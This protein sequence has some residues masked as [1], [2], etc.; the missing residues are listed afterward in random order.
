[1]EVI[2]Y[3]LIILS[4]LAVIASPGPA[5]LAIV[6]ASMSNGRSYGL[7]LALGVLTVS[8]FWSSIAAFGLAALL[9]SHA[10]LFDVIR[11]C[12]AIYLI[13]SAYK[14]ARSAFSPSKLILSESHAIPSSKAYKK[15]LLI[16]LTNPKAV[17]FFASLYSI[18]IPANA[19]ASDLISVIVSIGMVSACIFL[20]YAVI[21]SNNSARTIYLKSKA[22]FECVFATCFGFAGIKILVGSIN[23]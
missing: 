17:L 1:M 10:W 15:G 6:N 22:T 18:G 4:A 3:P 11:Y 12:G 16:Q 20:G 2:S 21:F 14:S 8:I 5:T 13:F 23:K 19:Q 9:Y 7:V